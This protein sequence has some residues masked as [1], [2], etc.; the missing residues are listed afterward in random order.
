MENSQLPQLKKHF[1]ELNTAQKKDFIDKFKKRIDDAG[2][3]NPEYIAFL[4]ECV[5]NYTKESNKSPSPSFIPAPIS[6]YNNNNKNKADP[7][8]GM[9]EE[10]INA[11]QRKL[12]GERPDH[13]A[14]AYAIKIISVVTLVISVII[15]IVYIVD[16]FEIV[17]GVIMLIGG[18]ITFI[19]TFAFAE[20]IQIL[21]DIRNNTRKK[22]E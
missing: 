9:T 22:S 3:K 16:G 6:S 4:N 19:F 5:A 13:N 1:A 10:E 7:Y 14:V 8:A 2:S 17:L 12:W 18:V 15:G 20:I 21:H 11:H